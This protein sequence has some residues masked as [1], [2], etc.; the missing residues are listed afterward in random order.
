MEK[1][2]ENEKQ[3]RKEMEQK[4]RL[5]MNK[6]LNE[7]KQEMAKMKEQLDGAEE[8]WKKER[9]ER[10]IE[11]DYRDKKIAYLEMKSARK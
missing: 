2:V 9:I 1:K 5:E 4:I 3:V 10:E 7:M 6:K 8:K 11:R